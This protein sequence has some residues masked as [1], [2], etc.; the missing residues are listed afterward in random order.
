M[1]VVAVGVSWSLFDP[2]FPLEPGLS[3]EF[4]PWC[5]AFAPLGKLVLDLLG[6]ESWLSLWLMDFW[7]GDSGGPEQTR[8]LGPPCCTPTRR[9]PQ[10]RLSSC[11]R[12][13][14]S[15]SAG[16]PEWAQQG[17]SDT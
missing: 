4:G 5:L 14:S 1:R 11:L 16:R 15:G 3:I 12:G 8:R 6:L 17:R 2:G 9:N 13:G 10:P 7:A